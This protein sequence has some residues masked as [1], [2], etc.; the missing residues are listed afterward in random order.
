MCGIERHFEMAPSCPSTNRI[1][2]LTDIRNQSGGSV[3]EYTVHRNFTWLDFKTF[4]DFHY[5]AI[6]F[7]CSKLLTPI[8]SKG[9]G[10]FARHRSS[11]DTIFKGHK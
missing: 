9:I 10:D 5:E 11:W 6:E 2:I 8:L 1:S 3:T 4:N 7:F